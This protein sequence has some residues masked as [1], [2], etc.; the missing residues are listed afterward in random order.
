[1]AINVSGVPLLGLPSSFEELHHTF[2]ALQTYMG[3]LNTN[4]NS[5]REQLGKPKSR[6]VQSGTRANQPVVTASE[7]GLIYYVTDFAH[8]VRWD[9]T[10]WA[11][12]DGGNNFFAD[13]SAPPGTG[14]AL[15][16]GTIVTFLTVG[17]TLGTNTLTLPNLNGTAAYKKSGS[18]YTGTIAAADGSSGSE[19]AHVHTGPSHTHTVPNTNTEASHTHTLTIPDQAVTTK[20]VTGGATLVASDSHGHTGTTDAGSAHSHSFSA[21]TGAAG[22]GDT[23]AGS[24]H[25]HTVGTLDMSRLV[26]LSYFRL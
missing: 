23:G 16:N 18:V 19:A 6:E 3:T 20:G 15:A 17:A 1:M 12:M 22:T 21:N 5:I 4:Y 14:W 11:F 8:M 26:T 25:L 9:G 10:T 2:A 7:A 24:S 13:F